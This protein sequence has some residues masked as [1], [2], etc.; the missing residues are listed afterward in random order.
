MLSS[1]ILVDL[2]KEIKCH[3]ANYYKSN[4]GC[5]YRRGA[6]TNSICLQLTKKCRILSVETARKEQ[7]ASERERERDRER[8]RAK[9]Y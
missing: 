2:T 8:E 4:L 9:K 1:E 6:I 5:P 3:I 7:R